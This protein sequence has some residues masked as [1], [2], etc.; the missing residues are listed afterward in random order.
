M[1]PLRGYTAFG[2]VMGGAWW[3][4]KDVICLPHGEDS[5]TRHL[6][7]YGLLG[8]LLVGT[9]VHP[10]NS[11]Y[12]FIAGTAVGGTMLSVYEYSYPKNFELRMKN[13]DE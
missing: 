13:V 5:Y 10:V 9:I 4:I 6:V 7:A 11:I 3:L 12:G 8:A 2:A 1:Y